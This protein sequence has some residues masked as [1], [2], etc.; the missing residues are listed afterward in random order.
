MS[1]YLLVREQLLHDIALVY[2]DFVHM[3]VM[4]LTRFPH[5]IKYNKLSNLIFAKIY[6]II[7][8]Y[9]IDNNFNHIH[10]L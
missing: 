6:V 9:K 3:N 8:N 10:Y 2:H 7:W 5:S 1:A 4:L